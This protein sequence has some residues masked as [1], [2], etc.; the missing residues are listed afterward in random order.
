MLIASDW[1]IDATQVLTRREIATVLADLQLKARRSPNT[2][3]NMVIFRLACCCGLRVSEIAGIRLVD[4]RVGIGRPR[5]AAV[6][7]PG[8]AGRHRRVGGH[9]A[10][11][12]R[13]GSGPGNLFATAA[14]RRKAV[15]SARPKKALPD[16]VSVLGGCAAQV[17]DD[18]PRASYLHQPRPGWPTHA[19]RS[20]GC[21]RAQQHQRDHVLP[22]LGGRK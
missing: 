14:R 5:R 21:R 2:R 20:P 9:T 22:A 8:D 6:V 19:G 18:P 17:P 7:G 16:R 3:M 10:G 1:R 13:P 15:G 12:G 4:V 11:P